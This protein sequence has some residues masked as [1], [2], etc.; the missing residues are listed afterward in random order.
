MH[1]DKT[2]TN[3]CRDYDRLTRRLRNTITFQRKELEEVPEVTTDEEEEE[4]EENIEA[5]W[6]FQRYDNNWQ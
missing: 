4:E 1:D 5:D 6:N 3:E 2:G